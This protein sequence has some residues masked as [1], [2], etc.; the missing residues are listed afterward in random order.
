MSLVNNIVKMVKTSNIVLFGIWLIIL[1]AILDIV[2]ILFRGSIY[3]GN[4]TIID[5]NKANK[6]IKYEEFKLRNV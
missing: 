2:P 3:D 4:Q 6:V 5:P 1:L